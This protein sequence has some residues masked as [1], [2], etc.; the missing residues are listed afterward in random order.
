MFF[1][2][3]KYAFLTLLKN[4]MLI[5][6]TF[7]FPIILGLFFNMAFSNIENSETFKSIDIAIIENKYLDE[8]SIFKETIDHLSTK[9]SDDQIFNTIYTSEEDALNLLNDDKII[10]FVKLNPEA[11]ITVKENGTSET[12]LKQVIDKITKTTYLIEDIIQNKL[13]NEPEI[14]ANLNHMY[15]EIAK[16]LD[17]TYNIKDI[18]ESNLSYTM[19]EYYTL[20]AMACLY[21]GILG[22][23]SINKCL[24]NMSSKGKR[25]EVSPT[26]KSTIILSSTLASFLTQVIGISI[27]LLFTIFILKVDFGSSLILVILLSTV[28]SLAGLSLGVFL[29]S[30]LKSNENLKLGIILAI[31]MFGCFLSG[32]MGITMKYIIDKNIPL[33]NK[34]NPANMITDG[35]YSL[36]YYNTLDRYYFNII[37]LIIFSVVLLFIATLTLRRKKYDSI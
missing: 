26:K 3:F 29:A 18:T 7:A 37:S 22:M 32:M 12:I 28:G 21:G 6:W 20:I 36:Y 11:T 33:I 16:L 5:F 23:T 31:T 8:S 34:L 9:N 30:I 2:N 1:H 13:N 17:T 4:K 25:V 14:T 35:F 10:G 15:A 19:I 27:L 24:A